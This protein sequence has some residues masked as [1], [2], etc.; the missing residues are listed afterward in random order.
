MISL[1]AVLKAFAAVS[2]IA[3]SIACATAQSDADP[4]P[5]SQIAGD[6]PSLSR[7]EPGAPAGGVVLG[8]L[9]NPTLPAGACGML[10]WM[11]DGDSPTPV[12]RYVS[13]AA[14][15]ISVSGR[16]IE[17]ARIETIGA[18]NFGV[19][20]TQRFTSGAGLTLKID[21]EFGTPF[22]GGAWLQNGLV[23]IESEDGWR[24]V[25]PVAGVAGCR[26]K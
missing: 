5:Q 22:E 26:A 20:E 24:S 13:G 1:N 10:I 18:S 16:M 2:A 4:A 8:K 15:Q 19:Y 17:L 21:V 3:S 7:P 14:A 11:L 9:A 25:A 23:A 6:A 12:F